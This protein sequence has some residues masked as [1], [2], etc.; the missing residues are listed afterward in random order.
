MMYILFEEDKKNAPNL[1]FEAGYFIVRAG[2]A[3][4]LPN[5]REDKLLRA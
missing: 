3:V 4:S 2:F 5:Y 1:E